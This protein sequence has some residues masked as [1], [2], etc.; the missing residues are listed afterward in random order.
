MY[1][2]LR[3]KLVKQTLS[4]AIIDVGGVGYQLQVP[5]SASSHLPKIGQEVL[6]HTSFIVREQSQTLYGFL[7]EQEKE[8][9][10]LFIQISGIG[11]KIAL[12]IIGHLTP[13]Q[14]EEAVLHREIHL[15]TKVPGIGKKSAE[16]LLME[17]QGKMFKLSRG[18]TKAIDPSKGS[19]FEDAKLALIN[20]GYT[21]QKA[22]D[23]VERALKAL[24]KESPI[25][26]VVT[27]ALTLVKS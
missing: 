22:S 8:L 10:E 20:L 17:L 23:A 12:S 14:L 5:L 21:S 26:S 4:E 1:A 9:F 27:H 18:A 15:I 2:F 25:S 7:E 3:G 13:Q 19:I 11:P 6:L 24:P 16:R